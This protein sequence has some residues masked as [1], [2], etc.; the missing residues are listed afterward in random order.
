MLELLGQALSEK[1]AIR[2]GG[3]KRNMLTY[4]I[5]LHRLFEKA[6]TSG[7]LQNLIYKLDASLRGPSDEPANL[8]VFISE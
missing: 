6:P 3:K 8:R 2:I 4:D 1:R 5:I 7:R